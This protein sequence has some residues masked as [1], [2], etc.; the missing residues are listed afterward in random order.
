MPVG[1]LLA[2]RPNQLPDLAALDDGAKL[3][4]IDALARLDDVDHL[5]TMRGLILLHSLFLESDADEL[6]SAVMPS[7]L[8]CEGDW[9]VALLND[10]DAVAQLVPIVQ[11]VD[12]A[13][14]DE[15]EGTRAHAHGEQQVRATSKP[16]LMQRLFGGG[17]SKT[18]VE[19]IVTGVNPT[20]W[21]MWVNIQRFYEHAAHEKKAILATVIL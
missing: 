5:D 17:R 19:P 11:S 14:L 13:K 9:G 12:R 6:S 21:E 10:P 2:L 7:K 3:D 20:V 1:K 18:K 16:G 15:Y 4:A 8:I